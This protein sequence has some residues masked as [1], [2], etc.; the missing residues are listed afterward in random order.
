M[1][2]PN[3][4][5]SIGSFGHSSTRVCLGFRR[6]DFGFLPR[7]GALGAA[8]V[9][10]LLMSGCGQDPAIPLRRDL[11]ETRDLLRAAREE[12]LSLKEQ[13]RQR[14]EQVR[15]LQALGEGKRLEKLFTVKR[16][17]IGSYTGGV[18]LDGKG[19]DDGV[20]VFLEP[21]DA[22]GSTIKAAGDVTI[23]LYDLAAPPGENLLLACHLTPDQIAD[24]W[25]NGF[26]T[27]YYIL[28]CPWGK[29]VP[30]HS[31]ITLR[32]AFVDYL[33]G[34]TFTDQ[35]VVTVTLPPTQPATQAASAPVGN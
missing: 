9:L 33:T 35:K 23:Q 34:L 19:G 7:L 14:D 28:E 30:R 3:R 16:V 2:R 12:N 21:Q 17:Q 24:K 29:N 4:H 25:T 31:E 10:S 13:L 8:A 18:D 1:P 26:L 27:Q 32:A 5:N 22:R 15:T 20:K 11:L 6:W